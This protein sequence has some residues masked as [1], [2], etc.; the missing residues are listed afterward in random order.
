MRN[1][2]HFY[3]KLYIGDAVRRFGNVQVLKWRLRHELGQLSVFVITLVNEPEKHGGD[4]LEILHS[5]VLQQ[6]W[7]RQQEIYVIGVAQGRHDAI[8]VV[9]QIYEDCVNV[10]GAADV[11]AYLFPHGMRMKRTRERGR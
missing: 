10:T 4:Q 9:R 3:R 1:R 2:I 6:P 7:Y 5:A 8:D 11:R